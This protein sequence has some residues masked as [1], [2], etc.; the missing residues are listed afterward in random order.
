MSLKDS[1]KRLFST[2]KTVGTEK[3]EQ[4]IEQVKG[5]AKENTGKVDEVINQTKTKVQDFARETDTKAKDLSEKIQSKVEE[6]QDQIEAK[7]DE[8]WTKFE[9]KAV[10]VVDNL[11]AKIRGAEPEGESIT[12][13]LESTPGNNNPIAPEA[14]TVS[15]NSKEEPKV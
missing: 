1:L 3:V 2:S 10:I 11:E 9:D 12:E 6:T 5:F 7:I 15:K 14:A 8:I 13:N 4:T